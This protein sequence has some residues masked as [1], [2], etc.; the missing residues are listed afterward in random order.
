MKKLIHRTL[1]V[2]LTAGIISL[3]ISVP[4]AACAKAH[5]PTVKHT[6][7]R[8]INHSMGRTGPRSVRPASG[9]RASTSADATVLAPLPGMSR[10]SPAQVQ[11]SVDDE[12]T[13]QQA[14]SSGDLNTAEA[15]F[16]HSVDLNRSN[17]SALAGLA[18]TLE[19]EGKDRQAIPVYRYLLYPKQGW[20]TS[21]EED[22]I[23]RMHFALLLAGDG[24][25]P[26]AVSV[27]ENTIGGITLGPSF[28]DVRVHFSPNTPQPAA[29]QAMAHLAM[30]VTYTNRL[31]HAQALSEYTLAL[32]MQPDLAIAG[33]CYGY[34]LTRLGRRAEA[35]AAFEQARNT[36]GND[37]KAAAEDELKG[38]K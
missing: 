3:L 16:R 18:Q 33:Y 13:G 26:E 28:P 12:E 38:F 24:Q 17:G 11:Q 6:A 30:G 10:L 20:G 4:N 25:W 15:D 5:P 2:A 37:V 23:L 22:P 1:L 21:L 32:G 7:K 34:G 29:L 31:E 27:Y 14:L 8:G 36:G 9:V 19:R 35:K